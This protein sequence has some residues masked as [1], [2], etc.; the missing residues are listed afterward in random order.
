MTQQMIDALH[1]RGLMP[2]RVWLQQN[3]HSPEW[4]YMYQKQRMYDEMQQ[5]EAAKKKEEAKKEI[6]RQLLMAIAM[7]MEQGEKMFVDAAADDIISSVN[8]ALGSGAAP[9]S[10]SFSADLGVMLGRALGEAPFKLLDALFDYDEH[11]KR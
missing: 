8:A 2:D 4:N 1:E 3:G 9:K 10:R 11:K 6:E 5:R 7:T